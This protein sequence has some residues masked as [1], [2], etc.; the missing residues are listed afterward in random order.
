MLVWLLYC[1]IP[2]STV[3][4]RMWVK[5]SETILRRMSVQCEIRYACDWREAI[6]IQM[7]R[8]VK[9]NG[10]ANPT[11]SDLPYLLE[12]IG[13]RA[14]SILRLMTVYSRSPTL[15]YKNILFLAQRRQQPQRAII[16]YVVFP[17]RAGKT[18]V[19]R[20]DDTP[21]RCCGLPSSGGSV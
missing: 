13:R 7:Q 1:R 3:A 18:C 19:P 4:E 10:T 14:A 16:R 11:E 17:R 12:R 5:K 6:V 2:N 9:W 8:I 20:M 15:S 21:S